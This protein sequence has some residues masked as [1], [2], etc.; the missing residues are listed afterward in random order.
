MG[1][2]RRIVARTMRAWVIVYDDGQVRRADTYTRRTTADSSFDTVEPA[3]G[4]TVTLH[5]VRL[6]HDS[7]LVIDFIWAKNWMYDGANTISSVVL[8]EKAAA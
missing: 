6:P 5:E 3:P 1:M 8:S 2:E 4:Q 7:E